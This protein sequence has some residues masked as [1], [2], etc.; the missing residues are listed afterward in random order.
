VLNLTL[1]KITNT[2]Y[3]TKYMDLIKILIEKYKVNVNIRSHNESTPLMFAGYIGNIEIVK[4]LCEKG[5][6]TSYKNI[7]GNDV[8]F[9]GN[10]E[11]LDYL[12][13]RKNIY[14]IICVEGASIDM[15]RILEISKDTLGLYIRNNVNVLLK[16]FIEILKILIGCII[17][18][19]KNYMVRLVV[20][21]RI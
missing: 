1:E 19:K 18:N 13:N 20:F 3:I 16:F 7:Y 5:A 6:K 21:Y 14:L 10:K 15:H 2:I 12:Y 4:Y 9:Y 17:L 8:Y 11:I